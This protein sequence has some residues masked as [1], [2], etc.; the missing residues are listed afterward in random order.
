M[1]AE[2]CLRSDSTALRVDSNAENLE[3]RLKR[4]P[5]DELVD[6][7]VLLRME[8]C[9]C[10]YRKE[11]S[12]SESCMGCPEVVIISK[13]KY[14]N[15]LHRA[16]TLSLV[17]PQ[18]AP[19]SVLAQQHPLQHLHFSSHY[20]FNHSKLFSLHLD[21]LLSTLDLLQCP[22]VLHLNHFFWNS[23][24]LFVDGPLQRCVMRWV[25][26]VVLDVRIVVFIRL[27]SQKIFGADG[28]E[29]FFCT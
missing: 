12:W 14:S 7:L 3:S 8:D 21:L 2:S 1:S 27:F 16:P 11:S 26:V 18:V 13:Y 24:L 10:A 17:H 22:E 4:F 20:L 9:I 23:E 5:L 28:P 15:I 25:V 29:G 19:P 6:E